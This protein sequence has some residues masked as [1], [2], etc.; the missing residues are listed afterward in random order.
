MPYR[1]E[2]RTDGNDKN[3][4]V[5]DFPSLQSFSWVGDGP[6]ISTLSDL[7]VRKQYDIVSSQTGEPLAC[8]SAWKWVCSYYQFKEWPISQKNLNSATS[9]KQVEFTALITQIYA[10]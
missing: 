5:C 7:H 2:R 6:D 10:G 3:M 9:K 4:Y 1:V 8:V